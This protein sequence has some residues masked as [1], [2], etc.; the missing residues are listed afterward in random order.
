VENVML[1]DVYRPGGRR[2]RRER[3]VAAL[4]SV[5]LSHRLEG[6]PTTLSGG[7]RQR[8]AVA[9]A[10]VSEP[11]IVLADE[12]T[13]NLDS[14][15][16]ATIMELFDDLHDQGL[17]VVIITHDDDVAARAD[18]LVRIQDGSLSSQPAATT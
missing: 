12:P 3:A 14:R 16:S 11:S 15:T 13:G 17:T 1:A 8:V 4:E 9:R 2:Q 10:L 6:F 7:E 18:R 5:G